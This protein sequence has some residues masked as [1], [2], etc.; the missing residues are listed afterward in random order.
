MIYLIEIVMFGLLKLDYM[1]L[2]LNFGLFVVNI[3]FEDG[4][5]VYFV[6]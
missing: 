2:V 1:C 5:D 3:Y 4:M 6:C